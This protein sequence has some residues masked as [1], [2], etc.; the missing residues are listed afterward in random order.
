MLT[1]D[2]IVIQ[3]TPPE[4]KNV[5]W[6]KPVENGFTLYYYSN[7]WKP[8]KLGDD[9]ATVTASG[10][11]IYYTDSTLSTPLFIEGEEVE[12][13]LSVEEINTSSPA[14]GKTYDVGEEIYCDVIIGN[15]GS[16]PVN[17][18]V[19]EGKAFAANS[20]EEISD[21]K[22]EVG[23]LN[24][25]EQSV[26][27]HFSHTVTLEDCSYDSPQITFEIPMTG[28]ASIT[29]EEVEGNSNSQDFPLKPFSVN[30]LNVDAADRT[31]IEG[32]TMQIWKGDTLVEEWTSAAD[33]SEPR[34]VYGLLP[35]QTYKVHVSE[36]AEDYAAPDDFTFTISDA[37]EILSDDKIYT[38]AGE[39]SCF[40]I[41]Q[42]KAFNIKIEVLNVASGEDLAG[43]HARILDANG[44]VLDEW[45]TVEYAEDESHL[46]LFRGTDTTY[47]IDVTRAPEGFL[48]REA[49]SFT[50]DSTG[51][52]DTEEVVTTDGEG[53]PIIQFGL[54]SEEQPEE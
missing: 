4:G 7:G 54:Y 40:F 45:D 23:T 49:V 50:I 37:G 24:P 35:N 6:G 32:N 11:R 33:D 10:N 28:V 41:E 29:G 17:N 44:Y 46:H 48:P 9:G 39:Y 38:D 18:I 12:Y 47:F 43:A 36:A 15:S 5:L 20:D 53:N 1:I 8:F 31:A 30:F 25:E 27:L 19:V 26:S 22:Y 34:Y 16:A 52:V 2:K 14:D 21:T 13:R 3:E 51:Q 42:N